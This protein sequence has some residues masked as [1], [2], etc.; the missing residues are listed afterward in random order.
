[1]RAMFPATPVHSVDD[2][3][4]EDVPT[5][6]SAYL[7]D[8]TGWD[9]AIWI[10]GGTGLIT[11]ETKYTD[12]LDTS[13]PLT[14]KQRR[15]EAATELG[16]FSPPGWDFYTSWVRDGTPGSSARRHGL[17]KPPPLGAGGPDFDQMGATCCSPPS[18]EPSTGSTSRSTTSWHPRSMNTRRS[19]CLHRRPAHREVYGH[20]PPPHP[21]P[22]RD[23]RARRSE[24]TPTAAVLHQ[25]Q[26]RYLDLTPA[27]RLAG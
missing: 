15:V 21:R 16:L 14:P 3:V 12:P 24:G 5:L 6:L 22:G 23:R 17:G 4:V 20:R 8:K 9:A 1:M 10:N 18:T 26:A 25:F 19:S 13:A 2:I 11:I 7:D 27:R